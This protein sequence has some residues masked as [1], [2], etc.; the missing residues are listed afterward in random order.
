[1]SGT[2]PAIPTPSVIEAQILALTQARGPEKSICP[3]EVAR[4][5]QPGWQRLMT[6][7][8]EAA[9]RLALAGRIEILRKGRPVDPKGFKGV[10]RLRAVAGEG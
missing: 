10:I 8:R 4:A 9:S 7:V 1:M 3:S 2:T 6:P 5:L